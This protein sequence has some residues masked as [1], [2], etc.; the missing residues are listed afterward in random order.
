MWKIT[1]GKNIKLVKSIRNKKYS[2]QLN[3][4]KVE[5]IWDEKTQREKKLGR[6]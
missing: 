3:Y 5:N 1:S 2:K 4:Q 6:I